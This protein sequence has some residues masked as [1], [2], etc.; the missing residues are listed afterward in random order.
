MPAP[1]LA[2][3]PC[4]FERSE[5]LQRE[6]GVSRVTAD[7][8]VRRGLADA[9]NARAF[10]RAARPTHA[11][12]LLGDMDAACELI[13]AAI[14]AR[15]RIVVHGDY[16]ADGI[17]ATAIVVRA[18]RRMG[19]S[20]EPFL[21]SRFDEGYGLAVE[22]VERLAE[23]GCGLLL[24][25][26]CGI[27][28]VESAARAA[29][30]GLPLIVTDH[31]R[32]GDDGL[33]DCPIVAVNGRAR[34]PE[35]LS[36]AGVAYRLCEELARRRGIDRA[37]VEREL[38]LVALASVADLVPLIGENRALVRA[39]LSRLR[40]SPRPGIEALCRVSKVDRVRLDSVAIGFRLA[41]RIN[42]AG[43]MGHPQVALELLLT[44]D[45]TVAQKLAVRLDEANRDRQ[46]VEQQILSH[47][48]ATF[49]ALPE[50]RRAARG[51]V[52]ASTEWHAGVIGIVASR[53]V[54][55]L[56]R[57]VVLIALDG[58]QGRGSGR[59]VAAFD[60]H[61]GLAACAEHLIAYGGHRAAAG[62]T[63]AAD[64]I[65][66]FAEAFAAHA[67]AVLADG[68]LQLEERVDGVASL[69][70]LSLDLADEL[71]QLEPFGIANPSPRLLI[72][73][74]ELQGVTSLGEGGRHLRFTLR[75]AAG[76]C[77]A[78]QWGGGGALA[79]L[80]QG[81]RFDVVARVERND[82]NGSS[83]VRLVA[84]TVIPI[85]DNPMP[86]TRFGAC[87]TACDA[88]CPDLRMPGDEDTEPSDVA[89]G[90]ARVIDRRNRSP[91]AEL[92]RILAAGESTLILCSDVGRRRGVVERG[93]DPAR[94]GFE[95]VRYLSSRCATLAITSRVG[96]LLEGT[97]N[98]VLA[99]FRTL[100]ALPWLATAFQHVV[101]IDP[102]TGDLER[103]AMCRASGYVHLLDGPSERD[104]A[105]RTHQALAPRA[106]C[107][108]VWRALGDGPAP[109]EEIVR[110]I[111]DADVHG[112]TGGDV[113]WGIGVL[114][115]A[116]FVTRQ[117]GI[118]V[119]TQAPD[120]T[121]LEDVPAYAARL[122]GHA[123]AARSGLSLVR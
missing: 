89:G 51:V 69:D 91:L 122:D 25:V 80:S 87:A 7:V 119:R 70:D 72:P 111:L 34:Y 81:G 60:L 9:G 117:D 40:S 113:G 64:A 61:A 59:S 85:P 93:V 101:A 21:P 106:I 44:D 79:R 76:N 48:I 107:A 10:M 18:L 15:D 74:V 104:L 22:T 66:A 53:M 37:V 27:T 35:E 110:R 112:P 39:G 123:R 95:R 50:H 94:F 19:A 57:P 71:A 29:E 84:S 2:I 102:P 16:D 43:R 28:A 105:Q 55:R 56:G 114:E 6:L 24:T 20:V 77:R 49:D 1:K 120:G 103:D 118:V 65:E 58:D 108:A 31:H 121:S 90:S 52:L 82:W 73:G 45:P 97:P 99:E 3:L 4:P 26:D 63:V 11:P 62:V 23:A 109:P 68:D 5:R 78:V 54:E 46:Q 32:P 17:C 12:D 30:L 67:D 96:V 116:G 33:P 86:G 38:D 36:G 100:V 98:L 41:P 75:S 88:T 115:T 14:D 92:S 83:S 13:G 47:A 42:A 8:L